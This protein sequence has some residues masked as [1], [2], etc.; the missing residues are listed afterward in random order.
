MIVDEDCEKT[1][2]EQIESLLEINTTA[3][4]EVNEVSFISNY[5]IEDVT[6]EIHGVEAKR[7]MLTGNI[8]KCLLVVCMFLYNSIF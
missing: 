2:Q 1:G 6:E 5:I 7:S 3:N 8:L 4:S